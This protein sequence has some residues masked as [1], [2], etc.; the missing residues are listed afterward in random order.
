MMNALHSKVEAHEALAPLRERYKVQYHQLVKF[1]FECSNLKYLTSLITIPKLPPLPTD[2]VSG[3][4][5]PRSDPPSPREKTPPPEDIWGSTHSL[6]DQLDNM[7]FT[8]SE[9]HQQLMIHQQQ[10]IQQNNV[11]Q[12]LNHLRQQVAYAQQ[13]ISGYEGR[14]HDMDAQLRDYENRIT[15][16]EYR[17]QS[18]SSFDSERE[19]RDSQKDEFIRSLQ[20]QCAMWKLKY[21]NIAKM[22]AQLRKEHLDLLTKF[23]DYQGQATMA[24]DAVA[25]KESL[26]KML[27]AKTFEVQQMQVEKDSFKNELS[28]VKDTSSSE[29]STLRRQVAESSARFQELS[30]SK[31]SETQNLIA[32]FNTEKAEMEARLLKQ[33]QEHTMV[34]GQFAELKSELERLRQEQALKDEELRALHAGMNE[35]MQA[36]Q[37]MNSRTSSNEAEMMGK[38]DALHLEHRS[39]MDKIMDSVLDDCKVKV[40]DSLFELDSAAHPGNQAATPEFLLSLMEK[41]MTTSNDFSSNFSKHIAGGDMADEHVSN[42]IRFANLLSQA[43]YSVLQNTKGVSRLA[44]ND[45]TVDQ[46]LSLARIAAQS[47]KSFFHAMQSTQLASLDITMRPQK[48]QQCNA[49]LQSTIA[50]IIKIAETL[51]K[52]SNAAGADADLGDFVEE[53]MASA[54]KAIDDAAAMLL[55]LLGEERDPNITDLDLQVH[56][57]ILSSAKAITDAMSRLII[58]ATHAQ[59]EI[60]ASGKGSG[61]TTAFYKKNNRWMEGL[62][63]AAKAVAGATRTLV[64]SADGVVHGTQ[65]MEHLIVAAHEVAASTAQLVAASRV[66]AIKGS[67]TQDKLEGA[68]RSVTDAT[69]L[70]VKAADQ[71]RSSKQSSSDTKNIDLSKLS[72]TEFKKTEMEQQVRILTLGKQLEDARRQLADMRRQA[73]HSE[74]N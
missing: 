4:Q 7:Q 71:M 64:E 42:S 38:I 15:N 17:I 16:Y 49:E 74:S 69:K 34:N 40:S 46:M 63:S 45:A 1:Y 35:S 25:Q 20:E 43:V 39:Q 22:Y 60:V 44:S 12:E 5:Q 2:F 50:P 10:L 61:S 52:T 31:G 3:H 24:R 66:K 32:Q 18:Q 56:Q 27:S 9:S 72:V 58:C 21:E 59:K 6:N 26:A 14:I 65:S 67:K 19:L 29:L 37:Q 55:K 8:P 36:I 57:S 54:A 11:E 62:I 48:V 30:S 33:T 70:L 47:S 53:Q 73:Y 68:A 23:K 51:V 41:L 13:M 28:K